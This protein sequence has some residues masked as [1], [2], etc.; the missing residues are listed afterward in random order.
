MSGYTKVLK[1]ESTT[2]NFFFFLINGKKKKKIQQG[3]VENKNDSVKTKLS[4]WRW[5][6]HRKMSNAEIVLQEL[7]K[8]MKN[9]GI[10][11]FKLPL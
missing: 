7:F 2:V 4:V 5:E 1:N 6:Q 10:G 9:G 3:T 8:K 11:I